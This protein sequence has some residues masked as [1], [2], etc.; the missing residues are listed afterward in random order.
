MLRRYAVARLSYRQHFPPTLPTR[1]ATAM[2]KIAFKSGTR[3]V[4]VL[5][6]PNVQLLD[7]TGPLQVFATANE[8][9]VAAGLLDARRAVTHWTRCAELAA[10]FPKVCVEPDPI[11]IRDGAVWTSAGIDLAL[12][13]I[14]EDRPRAGAGRGA[15]S[16]RVSQAARRAGPVQCSAVAAAIGRAL[17]RIA[18]VDRGKSRSGPVSRNARCPR[19]HERTQLRASL[20]GADRHHASA[21]DRTHAAGGDATFAWRYPFAREARRGALRLRFGGDDAGDFL[22]AIGVSR[23]VCGTWCP[24]QRGIGITRSTARGGIF[25]RKPLKP[26]S[27]MPLARRERLL[28]ACDTTRASADTDRRIRPPRRLG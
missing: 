12:A 13:L 21:R 23:A 27:S 3:A 25:L 7:V 24:A 11:F 1:C 2:T 17:R 5:A 14:E 10:R 15:A 6:F 20:P 26:V 28:A 8:V 22:C 19:R 18:R 9:S 4:D 16:R